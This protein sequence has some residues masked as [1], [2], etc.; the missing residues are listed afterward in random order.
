MY[1]ID[2]AS[3]NV[4]RAW[5][6]HKKECKWFTCLQGSFEVKLVKVDDFD[7][8]DLNSSHLCFPITAANPQSLF[9]PG[10]YANGFRALE[11]RSKLLVFSNFTLEESLQDDFRFG[12]NYWPLWEN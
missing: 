8:P 11:E 12:E 10:G 6:A 4:V 1:I 2:P 5:Q 3:R 9:I 7:S